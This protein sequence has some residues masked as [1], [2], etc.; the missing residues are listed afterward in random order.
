LK[1]S[2]S[3]KSALPLRLHYREAARRGQQGR[4][5]RQVQAAGRVAAGAYEVDGIQNAG[6]C[7]LACAGTHGGGETPHLCR[8]FALAAQGGQQSARHRRR[9]FALGELSH[10]LGRLRL[11]EVTTLQ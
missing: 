8:R 5:G 10:E 6:K 11:G 4:A 3:I 1:P 2:C 7:R 9:Q